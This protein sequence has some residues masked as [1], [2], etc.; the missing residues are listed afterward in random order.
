MS[1]PV[2]ILTA[3]ESGFGFLLTSAVLYFVLSRGRK[4]YHYLFAAF[5]LICAI[6]DLGSFLIMVRNE[7]VEELDAIGRIII[8]PCVFIPAL[9]F[10]FANLYTGRPI[11]WAVAL[12][13]SLTFL[14]WIPIIAGVFYK[15]EGVHSYTWG[16][17]FKV[18]PSVFDPL[19]FIFWFGVNLTAC[20]LLLKGMRVAA[21]R[22]ERR[23]YLYIIS[24][25]LAVTFAIVKALVTMGIDVSFLVPL[26]M[27]LNDVFVSVIG[28]A[29][30]KDRL[31]DITVI[32]KKSAIY[33]ALAAI[34]I[35]VF[36]F[37]EHVL[38]TYFGELLGGHSEI[39]H[40]VSIAIGIAVLMPV[41]HR[42]EH[43]IEKYF[44]K[45][46]LEF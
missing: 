18:V 17:I 28:L 44:A 25:L 12:V 7:R 34:L 13:W 37:S 8:L 21:F 2:V 45:K 16:N 43:G 35:F 6:W 38:I 3:I 32:V 14:T 36:S 31:F 20:W 40:F 27:L 1:S 39:A 41:K 30:I 4:T 33:S 11:R 19:M 5:L 22:L 24:G 15:I 10:H 42:L 26:G 29:I 23:H 46:K 9:I